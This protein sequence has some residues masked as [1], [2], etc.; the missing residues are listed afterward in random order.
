[1]SCLVLMTPEKS[2]RRETAE[3]AEA[4]AARLICTRLIK[5]K[6][7]KNGTPGHAQFHA[8]EDG[9]IVSFQRLTKVFLGPHKPKLW[10]CNPGCGLMLLI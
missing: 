2:G 9:C 8:T 1:M 7:R 3:G 5:H 6:M 10:V 4:T